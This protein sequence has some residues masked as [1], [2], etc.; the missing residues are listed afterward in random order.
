MIILD[1]S[2]FFLQNMRIIYALSETPFDA[3]LFYFIN[4][5]LSAA[6]YIFPIRIGAQI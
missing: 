4:Y 2:F 6:T 5:E 1:Y 3:I